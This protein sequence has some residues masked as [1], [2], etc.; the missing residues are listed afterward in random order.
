M[1]RTLSIASRPPAGGG[2]RARD[3]VAFGLVVSALIVGFR[4]PLAGMVRLWSV[5]PMYSYG[6][7]VPFISGYLLWTTRSALRALE[8]RPALAPGAAVIACAIAMFV[9]GGAA[10]VQVV[11]QIAFL[12]ALVGV[13]LVLLGVACLRLAWAPLAY[14]LL[15]IPLWD[16]LT[17][18]L[19]HPFQLRSASI[20]IWVLQAVGIP[21]H[22]EDTIISLPGL[23]MEVARACSGV[24]YLVAVVA[25][26]LPLSYLYLR[27]PWRRVVL[28]VAAVAVAALSNGLRVALIGLLAHFEIGSP[29]HGPFHVL[30]GLFVAAIGY[31]VLFAGLRLLAEKS[32]PDAASAGSGPGSSRST[33]GVSLTAAGV[34][35]LI[36][37]VAGTPLLIRTPRTVALQGSLETLPSALGAWRADPIGFP[38]DERPASL[39]SGADAEL[40]RRYRRSDGAVVDVFVGYFESQQQKK[41]MVNHRAT[42]MHNRARRVTVA[43]AGGAF[44]V[45]LVNGGHGGPDT[46]FWYVVDDRPEINRY[47]VKARTMWSA[48]WRGTTNGTVVVLSSGALD[49]PG[50]TAA[51]QELAG[52]LQS[53]LNGRVS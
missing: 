13:V 44:D 24:N 30:H 43:G 15:M 1:A 23:T 52:L 11:Q 16:G 4:E 31:V 5:S 8:P 51:L 19:H 34:L 2:L 25:L 7:T 9:A 47:V 37:L 32:P 53:A 42:P 29:L 21:A 26:G 50:R 40:R 17:E 49:S 39:W 45:N 41:E 6:I 28:L 48:V 22:R 46:L 38:R 10:G 20:G 12:V 33:P 14:L 18:R 3:G 27:S 36:F 35:I